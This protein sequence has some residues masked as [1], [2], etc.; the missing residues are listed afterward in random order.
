MIWSFCWY[1]RS[2]E[3]LFFS[4][5]WH[6][7]EIRL[8]DKSYS[9]KKCVGREIHFDRMCTTGVIN[10]VIYMLNYLSNNS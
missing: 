6:S 5:E 3:M 2:F 7:S 8:L 9:R 1:H 4:V 10:V